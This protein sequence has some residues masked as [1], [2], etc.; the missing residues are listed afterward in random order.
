MKRFLTS[1]VVLITLQAT[2]QINFSIRSPDPNQVITGS[3][4]HIIGIVYSSTYDIARIVSNTNGRTDTLTVVPPD[5]P[6]PNFYKT[7]PLA[8]FP[9]NVPIKLKVTAIDVMENEVSDSVYYTY[10]PPP[11][12]PQAFILNPTE[13]SNVYPSLRIR[14]NHAGTDTCT[15]Y[16]WVSINGTTVFTDTVVYNDIDTTIN[17]NASQL[18]AVHVFLMVKDKWN[19]AG[20]ASVSIFADNFLYMLPVYTRNRADK[21]L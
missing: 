8:G 18:G 19:Q 16:L 20:S 10:S 11:P 1:L 2:A 13:N 21:R 12:K 15:S 17:V 6:F 4:L 7:I 5:P 9:Q 3:S 14:T